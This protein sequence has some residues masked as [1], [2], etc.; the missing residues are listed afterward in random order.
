MHEDFRY[1]HESEFASQNTPVESGSTH[2]PK[3]LKPADIARQAASLCYRIESE[4]R[5]PALWK[6]RID[7]APPELQECLREYM[8]QRW[9]ALKDR[10]RRAAGGKRSAQGDAAIEELS[11]RYGK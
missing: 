3:P 5:D 4:C 2:P 10:E 9:R 6:A 1:I 8:R 7:A 11:R